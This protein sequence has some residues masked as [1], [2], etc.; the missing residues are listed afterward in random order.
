MSEHRGRRAPH[1][2]PRHGGGCVPGPA[3]PRLPDPAPGWEA[4]RSRRSQKGYARRWRIRTSWWAV[5]RVNLGELHAGARGRHHAGDG[6]GPLLVV[7]R[8]LVRGGSLGGAVDL[9][10]QET[11]RIVLLL[12][13]VEAGNARLRQAVPRVLNASRLESFD[14]VGLHL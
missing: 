14:L 7:G 12:Q 3:G 10:Q 11:C 1:S 2:A 8:L 13:N 6:L 9:D 5:F 4:A